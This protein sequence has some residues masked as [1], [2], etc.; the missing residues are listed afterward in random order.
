MK[1]TDASGGAK[2]SSAVRIVVLPAPGG[3]A[4]RIIGAPRSIAS[5]RIAAT[6]TGIVSAR[7]I[8]VIDIASGWL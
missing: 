6:R 8:C 2:A 5:E 7:R 3:S 1:Y 4:A